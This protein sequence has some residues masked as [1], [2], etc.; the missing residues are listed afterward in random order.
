M[1]DD[2]CYYYHQLEIDVFNEY[3][4]NDPV[5][6]SITKIQ[7]LSSSKGRNRKRKLPHE[8]TLIRYHSGKFFSE[9]KFP[10]DIYA[11]EIIGQRPDAETLL[12][13]AIESM[14]TY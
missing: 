7:F 6:K 11:T 4:D 2:I 9:D 5:Y 13:N 3:K 10:Y 1:I 14:D 8:V 12:R